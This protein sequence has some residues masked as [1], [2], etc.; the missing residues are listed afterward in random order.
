VGGRG[1]PLHSFLC[2]ELPPPSTLY[3]H[4]EGSRSTP[5]TAGR[6][7]EPPAYLWLCYPEHCVQ[8]RQL[9][10]I[11]PARSLL[12]AELPASIQPVSCLV[13]IFRGDHVSSHCQRK[14]KFEQ[15]ESLHRL[16]YVVLVTVCVCEAVAE[17][18]MLKV[19]SP[20]VE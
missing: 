15:S 8:Y 9:Y 18:R 11:Q 20:N 14:A 7:C 4:M 5:W 3:S 2:R 6:W 16:I 12:Q 13:S 1:R 10:S 19:E 17:R